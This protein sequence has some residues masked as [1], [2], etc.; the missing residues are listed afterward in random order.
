MLLLVLG[1]ILWSAT[2]LFIALAP[3]QRAALIGKLG[4]MPYKGLFSVVLVL[5]LALMVM[6][7]KSMPPSAVWNPPAGMRHLTMALMPIAAILFVSA[8][9]PTD[10]KQLIRHPQLTS[11]KLW[12][13]AHLLSNGELRSLILFTGLLAWAVLEV[14]VINRRDGAWN[15][16]QPVGMVKTC[17]FVGVGL[18]FAAF[19]MWAHPWLSGIPLLPTG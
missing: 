19:L 1:L 5:A 17:A 18:F 6:G 14:I 3:N 11:V 13:V 9:A 2:H 4:E 10:I 16:P 7:W 12:A 8:R 15:K